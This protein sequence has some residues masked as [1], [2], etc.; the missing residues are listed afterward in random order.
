MADTNSDEITTFRGA[1]GEV[2]RGFVSFA[3]LLTLLPVAGLMVVLGIVSALA[4]KAMSSSAPVAVLIVLVTSSPIVA[5]FAM[6]ARQ[7]DL[8][9]GFLSASL[10]KGAV[11]GFV[12]RHAIL[13]LIWGT[14]L[15]LVGAWLM[16]R[17]EEQSSEALFSSGTIGI[18]L[19]VV[20][21]IAQSLSL[22]VAT[23]ADTVREALSLDVWH[24]VWG[25]RADWAPFLAALIGGAALFT[26]LVWPVFG[27]LSLWLTR[28]SPQA[29][30]VLGILTYAAPGM[31]APVLYGRLCGAFVFGEEAM[32]QGLAL[33]PVRVGPVA[34]DAA[35]ATSIATIAT[36]ARTPGPS[37][38]ARPAGAAP[39]A[40]VQPIAVVAR[41]ASTAVQSMRR[42][43]V[44]QALGQLRLKAG[45]DLPG[46]VKD[47]QLLR[48][49]YPAHP[50]VAAELARV[51]AKAGQTQES[52]TAAVAAIK[53]A[54]AAG[55]GPVAVDLFVEFAP[56]R[57]QLDLQTP[58]LEALG[59]IS[60][61]RNLLDDALWCFNS[62]A[63]L[64]GDATKVQKGLI[65]VAEGAAKAGNTSRAVEVFD[66][67]LGQYP[68]SPFAAYVED[69][70]SRL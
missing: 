24:W 54:I 66:L 21:T 37:L 13:V 4:M 68:D 52:C 32:G 41:P 59:R 23:K 2:V 58:A 10:D 18:A 9:C 47:A 35:I 22:L 64:G 5:R 16:R 29:G 15:A 33:V 46:A 6:A 17:M 11:T 56:V 70:K 3:T 49:A 48:E 43:P 12:A 19:I 53:T 8:C 34:K 26:A 67:L 20:G 40:A 57:H 7:G 51:L 45:S 60:L 39:G 27:L 62:L 14:P 44:D 42:I 61:Q 1:S 69:A 63:R 31:A 38:P 65:A 50:L 28:S 25:R 55:T 36:P 30:V